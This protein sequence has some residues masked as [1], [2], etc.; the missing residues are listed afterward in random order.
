MTA[1]MKL[2]IVISFVW[3]LLGSK[4]YSVFVSVGAFISLVLLGFLV[5]VVG[6]LLGG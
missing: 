2:V 3:A 1:Y 5:G 6:Q 4:G